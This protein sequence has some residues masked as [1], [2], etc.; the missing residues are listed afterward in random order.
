VIYSV[1]D[2]K[3]VGSVSIDEL[4]SKLDNKGSNK[5][6]IFFSRMKE[7]VAPKNEKSIIKLKRLRQKAVNT[8]DL[9]AIEDID[10]YKYYNEGF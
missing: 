5:L 8:N 7:E 9:E 4:L 6:E 10:W 3:K 1:I 2:N